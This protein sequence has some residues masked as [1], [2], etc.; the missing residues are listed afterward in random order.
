[1][2]PT[3]ISQHGVPSRKNW[4]RLRDQIGRN[5]T[6]RELQG[7]AKEMELHRKQEGPGPDKR[8]NCTLRWNAKHKSHG[9]SDENLL[10][11][12]FSKQ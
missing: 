11:A 12:Q 6:D 9:R 5:L 2:L 3:G 7:L 10:A 4:E 1:M 8:L